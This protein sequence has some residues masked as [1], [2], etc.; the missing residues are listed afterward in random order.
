[1]QIRI[2]LLVRTCDPNVTEEL[3]CQEYDLDPYYVEVMAAPAGRSYDQL[4]LMKS[5]ENEAVLASNGRVEGTAF[6][7]TYCRRLLKA[8]RLAMIVQIIGGALGLSIA[9]VMSLYTGVMLTPLLIA[10]YTS[11]WTLL[12]WLIPGVY[13]V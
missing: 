12:S 4:L 3:I 5:E 9:V 8:V 13:R 2:T 10:A 1:M 7:I 11:I 6:G